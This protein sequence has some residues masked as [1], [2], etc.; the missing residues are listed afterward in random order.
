MKIS[1]AKIWL[2]KKVLRE[3]ELFQ[4]LD[5]KILDALIAQANMKLLSEGNT[6]YHKGDPAD[7]TFCIII[8]GSVKIVGDNGQVLAVQKRGKVMGEIGVMGM[9]H[10]RSADVIALEPTSILEWRF[11]DVKDQSPELIKRLQNLAFLHLR[12][13][14]K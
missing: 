12:S 3:N 11:S 4:D 7:D 5:D 2:T 6:L 1:D 8:F 13:T 9:Q 14:R 10:T